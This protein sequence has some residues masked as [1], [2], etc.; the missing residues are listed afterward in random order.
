MAVKRNLKVDWTE[1]QRDAVQAEIRTAV[2][3]VLRARAVRREDF[4]FQVE[5]IME[6]AAALYARWPAA[7]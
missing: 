3:R 7:A 6:Q 5:R 4:D 1:P 2:R